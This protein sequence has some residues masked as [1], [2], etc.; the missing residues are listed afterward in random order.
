MMRDA[1]LMV[2]ECGNA[3]VRECRHVGVQTSKVG[4]MGEVRRM[5]G[6]GW[7]MWMWCGLVWCYMQKDSR[8]NSIPPLTPCSQGIGLISMIRRW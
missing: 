6:V 8:Y 2:E 1:E 5:C 3:G 4:D 7:R